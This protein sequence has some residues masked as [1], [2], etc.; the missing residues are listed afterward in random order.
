[1]GD[2]LGLPGA[3]VTQPT[4]ANAVFAQIPT[5][6]IEALP[7]RFDLQSWH[8]APGEVRLMCAFDTTEDDVDELVNALGDALGAGAS[9]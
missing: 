3:G 7:A 5:A 1:M 8:E 9:G 6:A 2:Q 4:E